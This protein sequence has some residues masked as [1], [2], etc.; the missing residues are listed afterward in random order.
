MKKIFFLVISL[1]IISSSAYAQRILLSQGFEHGPYTTDSLPIGW[2]QVN[3][4]G[5]GICTWAHWGARDSGQVMCGTNPLP[6]FSTKAYNTS[7]GLNCPW[8]CTTGATADDWV[9]TDSLRIA[10]GDSLIFQIQLGTWPDGLATYYIDT[11]QV[12][13]CT[14]QTPASQLTRL[15]T[16]HSLPQATNVWQQV[17]YNLST[18]NGQ[19]VYIGFRYYMNTSADGIMVNLDSIMVRNLAGPPLGI[20]NN[21]SNIPKSFSLHQNYPNPF[22]PSTT[23]SYD[24][25]KAE[26]VNLIVYNAIGQEVAVLVNEYKAAGFYSFNFDASNLPSGIYLY[27]IKAG[28]YTKSEKM[29]LI[30]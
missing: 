15:G 9:F 10:T 2:V 19:R 26:Y 25:P 30:K 20:Q 7:R 23:I 6:G 5:P 3:T 17:I 8:T 21:N 22:N 18:Y 11:M 24:L 4:Q 16:V 27:R 13:V 1:L 29:S 12:W 14:G 28:D